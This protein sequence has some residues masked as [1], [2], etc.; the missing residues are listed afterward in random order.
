MA[1]NKD[2]G[3]GRDALLTTLQGIGIK[4]TTAPYKE[5][6]HRNGMTGIFC[7]NLFLK[8]RK[9]QF[10]LVISSEDT[11]VDLKWLKR[12][13]NAARNFSFASAEDLSEHLGVEAG[14]VSPFALINDTHCK[15]RIILDRNLQLCNNLLNF[16]PLNSTETSLIS[17]QDLLVFVKFCGHIP[18]VVDMRTH[19]V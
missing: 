4:L 19:G 17:Y 11:A 2:R 12:C 9:G 5:R 16:H 14:C 3:G 13:L 10:Y 18:E 7:K 8:D 15:I 6:G 1:T